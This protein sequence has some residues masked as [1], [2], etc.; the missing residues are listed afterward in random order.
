MNIIINILRGINRIFQIE[1]IA[2]PFSG[3]GTAVFSS[4]QNKFSKKEQPSDRLNALNAVEPVTNSAISELTEDILAIQ[5]SINRDLPYDQKNVF[6]RFFNKYKDNLKQ[7][8]VE[9]LSNEAD[10]FVPNYSN[11]L[12]RLLGLLEALGKSQE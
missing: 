9:K 12:S 3:F 5:N 6:I 7:S 2:V 10:S 11:L 1:F 8:D 4:I